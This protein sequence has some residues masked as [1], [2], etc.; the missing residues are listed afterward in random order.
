MRISR[1]ELDDIAQSSEHQ[2]EIDE[3]VTISSQYLCQYTR[4]M[5]AQLESLKADVARNHAITIPGV[6][7]LYDKKDEP[8][9]TMTAKANGATYESFK[10][11]GWTDAQ[12][13]EHK[14]LELT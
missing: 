12:L 14:Y 7:G 11:L 10:D 13:I 8:I 1:F 6:V 3:D 5:Y 2:C 9:K 4:A